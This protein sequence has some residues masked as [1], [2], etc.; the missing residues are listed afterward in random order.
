VITKVA[1]AIEKAMCDLPATDRAL[2]YA[3]AAIEAMR[4]PTEEMFW[5]GK[6]AKCDPIEVY[7]AMIDAALK[8]EDDK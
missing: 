7:Q 1:K 4:E 2:A 8:P 3:K 6:N 5:S